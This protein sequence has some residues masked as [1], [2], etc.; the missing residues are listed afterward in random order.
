MRRMGIVA[1][2][3]LMIGPVIWAQQKTAAPARRR[4]PPRAT[5]SARPPCDNGLVPRYFTADVMKFTN[6]SISVLVSLVLK[7]F[8]ITPAL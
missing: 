4:R 8:G 3:V 5:R 6:A 7:S 2:F 1:G